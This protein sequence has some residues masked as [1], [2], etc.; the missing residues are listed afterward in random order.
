VVLYNQ[1]RDRIIFLIEIWGGNYYR[2]ISKNPAKSS[3]S[4]LRIT[5]SSPHFNHP[6]APYKYFVSAENKKSSVH[7]IYHD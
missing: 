7:I 3:C 4:N 6:P 5:G 1:N 2:K